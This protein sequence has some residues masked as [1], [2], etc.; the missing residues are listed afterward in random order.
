MY[1]NN[2]Y[3]KD[4]V[5][6]QTYETGSLL[7]AHVGYVL[8]VKTKTKFQPYFSFDNRKID[9]LDDNAN[10][11]GI[12]TN[13]YLSGHNSKITLEY[14]SLKYATNDAVNTITLQAMVYL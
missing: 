1:Q 4:F 12:G 9:V 2:D 3:G 6:G 7:H 5:L 14:Q 11:F 8:P 13:F 10:Q